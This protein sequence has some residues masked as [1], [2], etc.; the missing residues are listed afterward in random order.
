MAKTQ[1]IKEIVANNII[2]YR[3]AAGL[4]QAQMAEKINYSDKAVSKW[5]RGEALPDVYVL[6]MIADTC[7]VNLDDMLHE[8]TAMEK[9]HSFYKNRTVISILSV[10]LV[11]LVA[12]VAFV[13]VEI[14]LPNKLP[15]WLAFIYAIPVS[16]IVALVFN[17]L[18][19]G[20]IYN[21]LIV[22]GLDWGT[23]VSL[24][25]SLKFISEIR[26]KIWYL[27]FVAAILEIMI[28]LWYF[29]DIGQKKKKLKKDKSIEENAPAPKENEVTP[30]PVE[31]K[32]PEVKKTE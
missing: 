1:D 24:V 27:Y 19:G 15:T 30:I 31:D 12:V 14:V 6:K 20:R 26:D 8:E 5:E 4:T 18:W 32:K 22:S 29:L 23:A 2:R 28:I 10:L 11:W 3:K 21:M 13:V 16:F 7:G 25:L 17:N 9:L